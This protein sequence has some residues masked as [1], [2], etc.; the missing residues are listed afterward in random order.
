MNTN[1]LKEAASTARSVAED[2][3]GALEGLRDRGATRYQEASDQLRRRLRQAREDLTD[4]QD[5]AV[6]NTRRAARR[7][8]DYAHDNP[9]KTAG[10]AAALAAL[11]VL[12]IAVITSSHEE[13]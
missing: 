4:L 2:A 3:G 7:A 6:R 10:A 9:W 12:A 5:A 11:V 13:E 8:D 1:A